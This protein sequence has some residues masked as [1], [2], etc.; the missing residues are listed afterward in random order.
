MQPTTTDDNILLGLQRQADTISTVSVVD[1]KSFLQIFHILAAIAALLCVISLIAPAKWFN[2]GKGG[3]ANFQRS[4]ILTL[5]LGGIA[6]ILSIVAFVG[7]LINILGARS[8]LRGIPGLINVGWTGTAT[9]WVSS[10]IYAS[11]PTS[12]QQLCHSSSC[13]LLCFTYRPSWSSSCQPT[14]ALLIKTRPITRHI[15]STIPMSVLVS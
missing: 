9:M 12:T 15:H 10:D 4:G 13:R 7:V 5:I 1:G 6:F 11:L 8:A 14:S 2:K 3:M